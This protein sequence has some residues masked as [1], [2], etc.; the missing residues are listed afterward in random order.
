MLG[1]MIIALVNGWRALLNGWQRL[2]RLRVDYVRLELS[3][4]LPEFA[5]EPSWWQRRFLGA[6]TP[7]SLIGLRRQLQR[8][9]SDPHAKGV[10]LVLRNL[11]LGWA[12]IESLRDEIHAFR[13]LGKRVVAYVPSA[14]TRDYCVACAADDIL[15]PP[16]AYLNLLGVRVEAMFLRDALKSVGIEAEVVAVSPYKTGADRFTHAEMSEENREQLERL[17]DR[18]YTAI[19]AMVAADRKLAVE[20]VRALIDQAPHTAKAAQE[21]GLIDGT[22]YED[23]IETRLAGCASPTPT[24]DAEKATPSKAAAKIVIKDWAVARKILHL[25][26][27][28]RQRK[29]VAVVSVE[30]TIVDGINRIIPL[31]LPL[32]GGAMAGSD[33]IIQALRRV[34]QNERIAALVLHIDSPGGDSFASDLIWREV[35]RLR[36]KIPV[37][38]SMGNIAASGGYYIAAAANAIVAQPGTLTGSIG[39]YSLRPI[40]SELLQRTGVNTVVLSRGLRTGLRSATLP[41]TD[42]ERTAIQEMVFAIYD[43]FKQR[44]CQGRNL[45]A[46]QLEPVAGGRVWAGQEAQP[47]GLVDALGGLPVAVA[48]ARELAKLP[49]DP[50]A[51]ILRVTPERPRDYLA[52]QPF[53]TTA[54]LADLPGLLEEALR[55]RILTILPWILREY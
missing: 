52:P 27:R 28:K 51:P 1:S 8:I 55:P 19:V 35:Q 29:Y 9:G 6:S 26:Y 5:A 43:E 18:I 53:P 31:P 32:I 20:Q 38:V 13:S 42:D 25:P 34:E 45:G 22:C 33:S 4:T 39:V 10:L 50:T 11:S 15:M 40:V 41:P 24:P 36:Q 44:V 37:V 30:G 16:T 3:G 14:D 49:A 7:P 17:I 47:R 21:R 46:A 54:A 12:S 2:L 23:E 48:K